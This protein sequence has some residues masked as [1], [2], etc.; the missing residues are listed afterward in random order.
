MYTNIPAPFPDE[1]LR[2]YGFRVNAANAKNL[3]TARNL[4]VDLSKTT[5]LNINHLLTCHGYLAYTR[6][7]HS[8]YGYLDKNT[9][10]DLLSNINILSGLTPIRTSRY[11]PHCIK[12]DIDL[13]GTSYW[14]RIHHLHGV[15][16]CIKH[17]VS[18]IYANPNDGYTCQPSTSTASSIASAIPKNKMNLY[19]DS[20]CIKVFSTLS[21]ATLEMGLSFEF[22]VI[23]D[24][25]ARRFEKLK[26]RPYINFSRLAHEKFPPFWLN[27]HFLHTNHDEVAHNTDKLYSFR[28]N[29]SSTK[30]VKHYL[31]LMA[32]LWDDPREAISDCLK[33]YQLKSLE[34]GRI[35]SMKNKYSLLKWAS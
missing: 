30:L 3:M 18:L 1:C 8:K 35:Y 19:L 16:H 20:K 6:F 31:L 29:Y 33:T 23:R 14:H 4:L 12:D 32:L 17:D 25:I 9:H 13:F 10:S 15:D 2:G 27:H 26:N 28:E 21:I 5:G 34:D 11:C 24:A 22:F 7:S